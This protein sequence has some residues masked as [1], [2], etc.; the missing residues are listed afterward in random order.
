[1]SNFEELT[2]ASDNH[3]EYIHTTKSKIVKSNGEILGV[4]GIGRDITTIKENE[5][6]L[7]EQ[8]EELESIFN[9]TKDGLA[10]INL[11]TKFVKVNKAYCD[12]T[13]LSEKELL[14]TSCLE[15]TAPEYKEKAFNKF[16]EFQKE[17]IVDSF[18][19]VCLIKGVR[20]TVNISASW[21][22]DKKHV[23]LSM[24]DITKYKL[25][26]E[27]AK[28]AAMG[29]MIG[30]IAH[31]WRQ[32]LSVITTISS[33]IKLRKNYGILEDYDIEPDM[34]IIMNQAQY[35]STTID[36]FRNFIK[37]TNELKELSLKNTIEK[38][39]SIL[40]LFIIFIND[41]INSFS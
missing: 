12:I 9:T 1:M 13:G 31:Q 23:L 32:P 6:K 15:L 8:Q 36:D 20:I 38:T 26:E 3:K 29:E 18:E 33:G 11:E 30:N 24:K 34:N 5:N 25:F 22:P 39:L 35:L 19:K 21:M 7:K 16:K 28:L 2:F 40:A 41:C 17:G 14:Q 37:N 27:Q 4:V 10:V